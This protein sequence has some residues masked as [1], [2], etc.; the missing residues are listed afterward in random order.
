MSACLPDSGVHEDGRIDAHDV[1]VKQHHA[2]PPIFLDVVLE[3][4]TVL[5]VVIDGC[6]SIVDVTT[7]KDETVFFAMR[8]NFLKN[9]FLCHNYS[10]H[11]RWRD[12]LHRKV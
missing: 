5:S 8:Y 4:Y 3:F 12:M 1:F 2:L 6:Q 10:V 9:V 7:W 11:I